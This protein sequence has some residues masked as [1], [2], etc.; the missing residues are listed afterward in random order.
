MGDVGGTSLQPYRGGAAC[1]P[2][3]PGTGPTPLPG[4]G[5]CRISPRS[6]SPANLLQSRQHREQA[7]GQGAA[8]PS[9]PLFF[10]S[11]FH[12]CQRVKSVAKIARGLVSFCEGWT[13][14]DHLPPGGI[15]AS[16]DAPDAPAR[17]P[18]RCCCGGQRRGG[19]GSRGRSLS[20]EPVIPGQYR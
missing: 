10:L 11:F 18:R 19:G 15:P 7:S 20:G 9:P 5:A 14:H 8:A 4:R 13:P 6:L 17:L 16:G 1:A 2:G 12:R 3:T